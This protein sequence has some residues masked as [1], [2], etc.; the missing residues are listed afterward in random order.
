MV[1]KD[2]KQKGYIQLNMLKKERL[3]KFNISEMKYGFHYEKY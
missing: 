2:H 1:D 3:N